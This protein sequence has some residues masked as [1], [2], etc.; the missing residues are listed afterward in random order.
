VRTAQHV[1][2]QTTRARL[3]GDFITAA[4]TAARDVSV[5]WIHLKVNDQ[6]PRTVLLKDPFASSDERVDALIASL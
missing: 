1:A 3:R 2:P 5:D 4:R 6:V